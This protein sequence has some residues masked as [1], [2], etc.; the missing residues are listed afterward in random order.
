MLFLYPLMLLAAISIAVPVIIHLIQR[1]QFPRRRIA[2]VRFLPQ[3]QRVNRFD[4]R[5]IDPIQLLLRIALLI[6]IVLLMARPFLNLGASA[7]RNFVFV[8]DTSMSMG[9]AGTE[10]GSAALTEAKRWLEDTLLTLGPNDQAALLIADSSVVTSIPLTRERETIEKAIVAAEVSQVGS[11]GVVPAIAEACQMLEGRRERANIV[12]VL[13]DL[14]A[15]VLELGQEKETARI[16]ASLDRD[17]IALR[18]VRFGKPGAKNAEV[19][20]CRLTPQTAPVGSSMKLSPRVQNHSDEDMQVSVGLRMRGLPSGSARPVTVPAQSECV[21]DLVTRFKTRGSSYATAALG[22]DDLPGDNE[23]SVPLRPSARSEVLIVAGATPAEADD[24]DADLE[25]DVSTVISYALNPAFSLTGDIGTNLR[26]KIVRADAI[27]TVPLDR[28]QLYI[29]CGV[30]SLPGRALQDLR[31]LLAGSREHRGL[32]LVPGDAMNALRFNEVFGSVGEP[33]DRPLT[34][35]KLGPL[36]PCDPWLEWAASAGSSPIMTEFRGPSGLARDIRMFQRFDI[37]PVEGTEVFLEATDGSPLG[38]IMRYGRGRIVTLGFSFNRKHTNLVGTPAMLSF[39][40][41]LADHLTGR[42]AR[43]ALEETRVGRRMVLD[44][45]EFHGIHGQMRLRHL[46]EEPEAPEMFPLDQGLEHV[47]PRFASTGIYE[48][49]HEK[50]Y[51]DRSRFVAV[52][53]PSGEGT[54]RRLSEERT[55]EAFGRHG[56]SMHL[57]GDARE[58]IAA[59]TEVWPWVLALLLVL[60]GV[61]AAAGLILSLRKQETART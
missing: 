9:L 7:P 17:R 54:L 32:I 19:M 59:G 61:E 11:E 25:V 52:N 49:G 31:S 60:Y 5:L 6:L 2:T 35:A 53:N 40:W 15:N 50:R 42:D 23:F 36:V 27:G 16:R 22:A 56:H 12:F 29:L 44:L 20:S 18:L 1:Q 24:P 38:V 43:P 34:A 45:S 41:R 57:P 13:S 4:L 10:E 26:P 47:V 28:Y 37:S 30:S 3:D 8:L 33:E 48:F 46:A 58:G 14:S 21:I 55:Y 51:Q 39:I